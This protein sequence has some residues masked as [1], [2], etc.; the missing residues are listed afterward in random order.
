MSHGLRGHRLQ[1]SDGDQSLLFKRAS[2]AM[3]AGGRPMVFCLGCG[4]GRLRQSQPLT[5]AAKLTPPRYL[6]NLMVKPSGFFFL[7]GKVM[8]TKI[9]YLVFCCRLLL[10]L[11]AYAKRPGAGTTPEDVM[12]KV[13]GRIRRDRGGGAGPTS[14]GIP[15]QGDA[16]DRYRRGLDV[17]S[18]TQPHAVAVRNA[19][20][21][22]E[23]SGLRWPPGVDVHAPDGLVMVYKLDQVLRSDLVMRFF[24]G[25]GQ[26]QKDFTIAW[27]RPPK[28]AK[29]WSW[30]SYPKRSRRAETPHPDH[31][32][33]DLSGRSAGV[34]QCPR[35][36][37]PVS[38][39]PDE[40]DVKLGT[41]FFSFHATSRSPGG[42]GRDPSEQ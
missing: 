38:P 26:F 35:G 5:D 13:Q 34:C 21:T 20:G 12:K 1:R 9:F 28:G 14:S 29:A 27:N 4:T 3:A 31:Q 18:E 7:R 41:D 6:I 17:L 23:R 42:A 10:L 19:G 36:K 16:A 33:P 39:S 15:P 2:V 22:E 25:I 40:V 11:G 8:K 37:R 24:S 30:T 32:P